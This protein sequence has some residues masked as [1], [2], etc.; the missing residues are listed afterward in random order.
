MH[1]AAKTRNHRHQGRPALPIAAAGL[2]ALLP[3]LLLLHASQALYPERTT[4][5][6]V[7]WSDYYVIA[8]GSPAEM[9]AALREYHIPLSELRR[10]GK[11][12]QDTV[13]RLPAR[14]QGVLEQSPLEILTDPPF[15]YIDPDLPKRLESG[16]LQQV[17]RGYKNHAAIRAVLQGLHERFPD[18]TR[19]IPIGQSVEGRPIE[20][21]RIGRQPANNLDQ[22]AFLFNCG[23]HG[24]EVLAA[25]YC[26]DLAWTLLYGKGPYRNDEIPFLEQ[27]RHYWQ[28]QQN[29]VGTV[30]YRSSELQQWLDS[31]SIW[32]VPIVN[33]DGLEHLW[34]DHVWAGRKNARD[35]VAPAGWQP[36]DG[37]DLNRNYP[38][39]WNSGVVNA[40]SDRPGHHWYRGPAP[41]SEPETRAMMQLAERERF[42]VVF[43][44]HTYATKILTP[45]TIP[46]SISPSPNPSWFFA[47]E[48]VK[49]MESH[50]TE[51]QYITQRNLY[52]VDGTDQ[53]WHFFKNGSL[54][55]IVEGSWHNPRYEPEARLSVQ[56][57]RPA[58]LR[59]LQLYTEGPVIVVHTAD[60]NGQVLGAVH[61]RLAETVF[62]EQERYTTHPGTG[63]FDFVLETGGRYTII[64]EKDGYQQLSRTLDCR[65]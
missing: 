52:P 46:G 24:N 28:A 33:P 60:Q 6:P 26:T 22:P 53:D 63:R 36:A 32:I 9:S 16:Q 35:T 50:R 29:R 19:I 61:V 12:G 54:A 47:E 30:H 40:S 15:R 65:Q 57:M 56:G 10:V 2:R 7:F 11:T 20:A 51:R 34:R 44:Y 62:H 41:A 27:I 25:E 1:L 45:Y 23:H 49:V 8:A 42:V 14:Y 3:A 55:Y 58:A 5:D 59:A 17:M 31:Y 13:Y 4:K 21:L 48:L 18:D 64:A 38:F 43:S 37:V 39:Y